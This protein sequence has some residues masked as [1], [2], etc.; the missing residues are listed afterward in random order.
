MCGFCFLRIGK[1]RQQSVQV[2]RSALPIRRASVGRADASGE[3]ERLAGN[4]LLACAQ[5]SLTRSDLR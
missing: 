2:L 5:C 1:K 4:F 3:V